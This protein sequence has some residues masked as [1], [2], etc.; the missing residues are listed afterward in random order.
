[1]E[2]NALSVCCGRQDRGRPATIPV[3]STPKPVAV[4]P[5]GTHLYVTNQDAN[6]VSVIAL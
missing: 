3:G 4:S 2:V 5:D 1:L 6:T